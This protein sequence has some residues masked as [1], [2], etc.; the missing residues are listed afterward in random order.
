MYRDVMTIRLVI[1][2]FDRT[3]TDETLSLAEGLAEAIRKL[4]G[5]GVSFSIVSGRN[6]DFLEE[7][8]DG[9]DGLVDSFVAE[10]G[11]IGRFGGEKFRI[12]N[13]ADRE[14]LFGRLRRLGV[15]YGQGDVIVAVG[16]CHGASLKK[17]IGGLDLDVIR[18]VDSLMILP[19]GVSKCSGAEWLS[20]MHGLSR[21]E[22]AGI[23]DAENDIVLREACG[24]LGAVANAIP[25]MKAA[26]DYVC[27]LSHG[28]GLKEFIEY[29]DAGR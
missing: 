23:G 24:L 8:C 1:S 28:R 17:A 26:A 18:N 2:D 3:F 22:T 21:E 5:R 19:R 6:Y 20:R 29:I 9:L 16:S 10:N 25:E 27:T 14:A 15:P 4:R 12:G 11:C 13:F 7:F